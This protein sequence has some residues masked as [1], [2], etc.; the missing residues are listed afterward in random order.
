MLPQH[1]AGM[2]VCVCVI[3]YSDSLSSLHSH[4]GLQLS[5]KYKLITDISG[6]DKQ[7]NKRVFMR[8]ADSK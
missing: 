7:I 5:E 2:M 3:L 1:S 8:H 4:S 6:A